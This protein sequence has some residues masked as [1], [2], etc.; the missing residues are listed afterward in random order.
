MMKITKLVGCMVAALCLSGPAVAAEV[1]N[2]YAVMPE[3]YASQVVKAYEDKTG[4]KVNFVRLASG[5]ALARLN[6]E[7]NNPQVDIVLGGPADMFEAG[8]KESLFE[9]Y[10]PKDIGIPA[11]YR[12]E[13]GFWTGYGVNPL[14]FMTNTNFLKTNN[15]NA[16]ESWSDLLAP[17]YKNG[18]QMA[19]ARTSGTATE[20]IF[21]LVKLYGEDGAFD[22][23]KKLHQNVQL[24]TKSG[25]GGAM[26][27]AA[28]QASSGIFY[29]VDALDVQQQGYPVVITYPKEGT[30]YGVDGVGIVKGAKNL[31]AAKK[32]IDWAS[33]AEMANLLMEKKINYVPVHKDAKI[34][35]PVLDVSKVKFLPTDVEWK[36]E[37]RKGY[38]TRWI[39]EV[40]Q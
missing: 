25:Q 5:E 7:K 36:G 40:I 19:D 9:G 3:K 21:A 16:P 13:K 26:P 28:G 4:V 29:L 12:S 37:K 38:V 20:R 18:L 24:Y 14:V 17:A 1:L 33:S 39:N 30:T 23:Q 15:L 6:A 10:I 35:D 34:T 27:I 8:V 2:A 31:D 11:E 22:Y 32:F